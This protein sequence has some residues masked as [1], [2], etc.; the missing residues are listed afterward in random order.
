LLELQRKIYVGHTPLLYGDGVKV[1]NGQSENYNF[2]GRIV[3]ATGKRSAVSSQN[4]TPDW[5]RQYFVPF[6]ESAKE[7]PFFFAW[8]PLA[9]PGETGYCWMTGDVKVTNQ[10]SN[11]MMQVDF[12][13]AGIVS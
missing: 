9:Y 13:I 3:Q 7:F 12:S 8:R 5:Y 4:L 11:G 6:Q 10:R 1:V 2:T